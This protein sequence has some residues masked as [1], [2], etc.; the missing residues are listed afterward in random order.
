MLRNLSTMLGV[1][2]AAGQALSSSERNRLRNTAINSG[3]WSYVEPANLTPTW[4]HFDV[5]TGRTST[6]ID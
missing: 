1:A 2:F 4:V 6:T 3:V 5:G